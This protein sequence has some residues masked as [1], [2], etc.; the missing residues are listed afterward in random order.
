[1]YRLLIVEDEDIIRVGIK[2]IIQEMALP[3]GDIVEATSGAEAL[4]IARN[5]NVDIIV[6]DIKMEGGDGLSLIRNLAEEGIRAKS[7]ILSGYGEFSFAQQAIS[8]GIAEYLLKPVK[9]KDLY[10][11][12][13][14]MIGQLDAEKVAKATVSSEPSGKERLQRLLTDIVLGKAEFESLNNQAAREDAMLSGLAW[15]AVSVTSNRV[16]MQTTLSSP[17]PVGDEVEDIQQYVITESEF[18][19]TVHLFAA[20]APVCGQLRQFADYLARTSGAFGYDALFGICHDIG[21]PEKLPEL[22]RQS[23]YALD[24]RLLQPNVRIFRSKESTVRSFRPPEAN[25]F[26]QAI[27]NALRE[28]QPKRLQETID[29]WF[30]FVERLPDATP[31]FITDTLYHLMVFSEFKSDNEQD[32]SWRAHADLIRLYRR[33][34]TLGEFK[35]RVQ[36]RFLQISRKPPAANV[37]YDSH[38]ISFIIEY[39]ERHYDQDITLSSAAEQIFMNPSYFSTLFKRKTGITFVHYL[40]HLRIEKSKALLLESNCKIYEIA[41][42]TGFADEKYFFKVFKNLTGSTPTEYRAK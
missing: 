17:F 22:I 34:I 7:V 35:L 32:R 30:R 23:A 9:K 13:T 27:H 8:L 40:Q 42:K 5:G 20:K 11:A 12:L 10:A 1:M 26:T 37:P 16:N 4:T 33:S 31:A 39:L 28:N 29:A 14:K 38:A 24:F 6:T 18:G 41:V 19:Y 21:G 36:E 25:A 2:K 3:I 15:L